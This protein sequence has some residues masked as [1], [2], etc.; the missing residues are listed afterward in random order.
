MTHA[1]LFAAP[2][3]MTLAQREVAG[4]IEEAAPLKL[5]LVW[6]AQNLAREQWRAMERTE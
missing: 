2:I 5:E 6:F 3:R 4:D 1:S